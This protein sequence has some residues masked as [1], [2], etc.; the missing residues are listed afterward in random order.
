MRVDNLPC[1]IE[2]IF[3][4]KSDVWNWLRLSNIN[5]E[6]FYFFV[7][8]A[9]VFSNCK[10][11]KVPSTFTPEFLTEL[12]CCY[13]AGER[14]VLH[15]YP[16]GVQNEAIDSYADFQLSK[17]E[18]IVLLYDFVHIEIYCKNHLWIQ[19]FLCASTKFYGAVVNK[20]YED[21]DPRTNMYV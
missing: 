20:K 12:A 6:G 9:A 14:L 7:E 10:R 21:T 2:C 19:E 18:L 17:C 16:E 8:D 15:L 11:I 3:S 1:G 4:Q 13:A 5:F